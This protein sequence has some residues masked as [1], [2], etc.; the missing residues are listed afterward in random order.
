MVVMAPLSPYLGIPR[1][2]IAWLPTIDADACTVCGECVDLCANNVFGMNEATG[3][4]D[5]VNPLN[6]VVLCDKCGL[7]C[8]TEAIHF[9]DK[10]QTKAEISRL[11]ADRRAATSPAKA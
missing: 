8:P 11:L 10:P 2:Q 9:P 4:M 7:T 3:V 1:E 5:V 6:C